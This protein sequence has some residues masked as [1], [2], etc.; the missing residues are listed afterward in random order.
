VAVVD[1][2]GGVATPDKSREA[3]PSPAALE[4]RFAA[5][6]QMLVSLF[7]C[8]LVVIALLLAILYGFHLTPNPNGPSIFLTV[9]LCGVLGA[10]FSALIRLYQ[11]E[12]LPRVLVDE[13][14]PTLK[15]VHLLVY[16]LVPLV[17]GAI[18]ASFLYV[19]FTGGILGDGSLFPKFVCKLK[20][21][22]C[23]T[24]GSYIEEYGP[25]GGQDYGRLLVWA[26]VAGF[27]ERFV[28]D[29]L[30]RLVEDQ[31]KQQKPGN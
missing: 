7:F 3:K 26:F 15:N 28:P 4:R 16:S 6:R 10:L 31:N 30:R 2:S 8:A 1:A 17:V 24:F 19:A 11:Y 18:A 27:A 23:V 13:T 21:A 5:Y 22:G 9:V 14:V 20:E 12:D 25:E 29:T